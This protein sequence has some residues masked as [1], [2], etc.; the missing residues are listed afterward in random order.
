M[1]R[2][3]SSKPTY[4]SE[5]QA[6]GILPSFVGSNAGVGPRTLSERVNEQRVDSGPPDQHLVGGVGE[7]RLAIEQPRQ[8]RGSVSHSPNKQEDS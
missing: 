4:Y 2:G 1:F 8:L 5:L 3:P 6:K 7:D